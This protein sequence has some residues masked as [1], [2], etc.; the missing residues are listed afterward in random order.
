MPHGTGTLALTNKKPA[1]FGG[2]HP[3][4]MKTKPNSPT[5]SKSVRHNGRANNDT[6]KPT[7]Y[8]VTFHYEQTG[9]R[10]IEA[11]TPAE[12][13]EAARH[14]PMAEKGFWK[15]MPEAYT[16]EEIVPVA[17]DEMPEDASILPI[18]DEMRHNANR[19]QS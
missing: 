3:F 13:R 1:S 5:R 9:V 2:R 7:K 4:P 8:Q 17:D 16:V 11:A 14:I 6:N 18:P 15:D 19:R 12:A 10:F